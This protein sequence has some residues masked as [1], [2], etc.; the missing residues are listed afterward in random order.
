MR[1]LPA[2]L[3]LVLVAGGCT[4]SQ[5]RFVRLEGAYPPR[6]ENCDVPILNPPPARDFVR[7][8]RIDVHLEWS[9]YD[10]PGLE[11]AL[12]EIRKQACLAGADAVIELDER[13]GSHIETKRYHVIATGIKY[14]N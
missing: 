5:S 8:A 6:P 1:S 11:N 13:R 14:R 10:R 4:T 7:I 2:L 9:A 3:V 12:P